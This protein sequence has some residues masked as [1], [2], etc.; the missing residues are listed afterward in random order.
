MPDEDRLVPINEVD[1]DDEAE[2]IRILFMIMFFSYPLWPIHSWRTK[3]S[4]KMS[5]WLPE[6]SSKPSVP[7]F[8]RPNG[9]ENLRCDWVFD[10][11]LDYV[12]QLSKHRMEFKDPENLDMDCASIRARH[13]F[14]DKAA[15]KEEADFGVARARIVYKDYTLLEMELAANYAP[16]NHYCYAIDQKADPVFHQ[17]IQ[18]LASCF[19]N[20]EVTKHEFKV[21][22]AGHGMGPSFVQCLKL[23]ATPEKEWKYVHLLQNHDTSL[24]TNLEMVRILKWLNGSNDVEITSIPGGRVDTSLDWSFN[25]L[26]LFQNKTRNDMKFNGY[27]PTLV[28][29]KGYVESTLSR[30]MIDFMLNDLNLTELMRRIELK[31]FG[32]DEIM[33]PTLHASDAIA[34]PGGFTH[35]CYKS[36]T[37]VK[38]I[39]RKSLWSQEGCNSKKM[40][41][42]ICIYGVEDL[43]EHISKYPQMFVNKIMPEFDMAAVVCWY[44]RLF[45]RTYIDPPTTER[46]DP[47]FYLNLAHVRYQY[48]K[49][50]NGIVNPVKLEK[51]DCKGKQEYDRL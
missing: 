18:S 32:I 49:D 38:H 4:L 30:K 29:S 14:P 35:Y 23:L 2:L 3:E 47:N 28:F 11:D 5:R 19:P 21:D 26:N 40:R 22:S 43:V 7:R 24:R 46:L 31:G 33:I 42:A 17:R 1:A 20:V 9:T 25:A 50:A 8:Y 27:E 48:L 41:H 45:N 15:S 12:N 36:N 34:A 44:E 51:F 37:N 6:K 13:Y 39:T 16:Q 10:N